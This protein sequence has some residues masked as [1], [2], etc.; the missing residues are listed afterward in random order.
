MSHPPDGGACGGGGGG[1]GG[2]KK[3]LRYRGPT[4][5]IFK[6]GVCKPIQMLKQCCCVFG[7]YMWDMRCGHTRLTPCTHHEECWNKLGLNLMVVVILWLHTRC[8]LTFH[9]FKACCTVCK[10]VCIPL[11]LLVTN[12]HTPKLP[13]NLAL[14]LVPQYL[15]AIPRLGTHWAKVVLLR[16]K[17]C[18]PLPCP[19]PLKSTFASLSPPRWS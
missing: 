3:G 1:R 6:V 13:Y 8:T 19:L 16:T 12:V 11:V 10:A 2:L 18:C 15:W 5:L 4:P 14:S 7:L 9:R 17:Q